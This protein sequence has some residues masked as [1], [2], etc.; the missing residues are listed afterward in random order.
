MLDVPSSIAAAIYGETRERLPHT[1]A[2][3]VGGLNV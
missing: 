1:E 3:G 2:F